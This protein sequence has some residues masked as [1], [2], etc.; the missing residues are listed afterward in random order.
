MIMI[1]IRTS[2]LTLRKC[3]L[4]VWRYQENVFFVLFFTFFYF[5]ETMTLI[6]YIMMVTNV[7]A[8]YGYIRKVTG[9]NKYICTHETS[10]QCWSEAEPLA[11]IV[12]G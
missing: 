4:N 7:Q 6:Q 3:W 10:R 5:H 11:A 2:E 9:N 8:D 1:I 12:G